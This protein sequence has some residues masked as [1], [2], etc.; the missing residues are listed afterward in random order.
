MI[1]RKRLFPRP[2]PQRIALGAAA[3]MAATLVM[4]G[5]LTTT[6]KLLPSSV[7]PLKQDPGEFMV[8]HTLPDSA[9]DLVR[10][11]A[12]NSL[13]M[14]YGMTSGLLY[15]LARPRGGNPLL[16]GAL[17]GIAVWA[18]GYL[19]WL[20]A[21][22]LMPPITEHNAQQIAVP[23]VEHAIFGMAVVAAYDSVANR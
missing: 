18:A 23:I 8:E 5:M 3:G 15:A 6:K 22:D 9:P 14:G 10:K 16:E 17:L 12:E 11:A 19:G 13:R 1:M 4:Q 2:L 21:T 7:P 20:P